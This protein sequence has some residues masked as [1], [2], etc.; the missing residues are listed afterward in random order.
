MK[1]QDKM[2]EAEKAY[3]NALYYR[4]NMADML[5]NLWVIRLAGKLNTVEFSPNRSDEKAT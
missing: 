3:R 1:N 2:A 4:G 5:Y